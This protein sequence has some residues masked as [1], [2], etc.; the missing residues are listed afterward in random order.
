MMLSASF[1]KT[2][3][4]DDVPFPSPGSDDVLIRVTPC[5]MNNTDINTRIGW[6]SELVT[7]PTATEDKL[8]SADG[9]LGT[10]LAFQRIQGADPVGRIVAAAI[11]RQR[12]PLAAQS[13]SSIDGRP[14]PTT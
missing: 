14:T 8:A 12:E 3:P 4:N 13:S 5:G 11:T 7:G 9:S 6:Y 1:G 2:K 10:G